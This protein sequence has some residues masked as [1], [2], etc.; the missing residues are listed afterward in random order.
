MDQANYSASAVVLAAGLSSRM[1]RGLN[2]T[3][4]DLGHITVLEHS[5][6]TLASIP[7]IEEIILVVSAREKHKFSGG[8]YERL[9]A[10]KVK[11]IVAGGKRRFDS[12]QNGIAA[13]ASTTDLILIHDGA[14]P[15][16]P[17][18]AIKAALINAFSDGAAILAIPVQDTLKRKE[19]EKGITETISRVN[20][21]QSQTPQVFKRTLLVPAVEKAVKEGTDPT[22]EASILE[23]E[24]HDIILVPGS[25][26]NIKI[27]TEDDLILAKAIWNQLNDKGV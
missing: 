4:M 12:A 9:Q 26:M 11:R 7:A 22:D 2:K 14:R 3:L 25:P 20:L 24:G 13:C 15:F 1:G 27:T 23:K 10:L 17:I 21:F 16:A 5:L 6:K 18:D 19:E 8:F